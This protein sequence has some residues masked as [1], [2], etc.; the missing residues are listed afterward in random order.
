[1]KFKMQI[2]PCEDSSLSQAHFDNPRMHLNEPD[3]WKPSEAAPKQQVTMVN[4]NKIVFNA[5]KDL[6]RAAK[7]MRMPMSA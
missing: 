1:L 3:P 6:A 7:N 2:D 4:A 5:N